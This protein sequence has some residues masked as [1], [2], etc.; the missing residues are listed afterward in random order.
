MARILIVDDDR[1]ITDLIEIALS[2][3]GH[4]VITARCGQEALLAARQDAPDLVLLD[5]VMPDMN[6]DEVLAEMRSDPDLA[7]LQ[8]V[9]ATGEVDSLGGWTSLPFWPSPTSSRI[10]MR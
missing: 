5:L 10:C 7:G 9:L 2:R 3:L 1:Q 8:V 4:D 6:G